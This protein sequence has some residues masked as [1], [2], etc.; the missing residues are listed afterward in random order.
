MTAHFNLSG[1][2]LDGEGVAKNEKKGVY[3]LEQAAIGGHP[4][5][6]YNLGCIDG[7]HGKLDRAV[8][9][10]IIATI[11]GHDNSLKALKDSHREGL[12]SKEDFAAA[13]RA[14]H[15]RLP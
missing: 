5:A 1:K 14:H 2:Y 9:H 6:R 4:S 3:H 15:I 7:R 12:L 13:L 10:W 8:K 11:S